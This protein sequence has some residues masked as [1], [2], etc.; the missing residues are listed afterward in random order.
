MNP[1]E[2]SALL[3]TIGHSGNQPQASFKALEHLVHQTVGARLF[4]LMEL[5]RQRGVAWRNY[6]NMPDAY[7]VSGEKPIIE[8]A[9]SDTVDKQQSI[10]VAN[11]IDELAA[12]FSDYKLIQSL[13]C[14]SCINIP[15]FIAGSLRGTLNCLHESNHYNEKRVSD[16]EQLIAPG[17]LVFLMAAACR[18]GE[19][20]SD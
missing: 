12:V 2:P 15:I 1:A 5:D 14:E 4:T 20:H 19:Q 7:P 13:G 17:T 11:N 8:D 10:F 18:N 9:W 6:S 3:Q 16:A